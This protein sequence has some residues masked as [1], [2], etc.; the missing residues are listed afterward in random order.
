MLNIKIGC[1]VCSIWQ[2]SSDMIGSDTSFRKQEQESVTKWLIDEQQNAFCKEFCKTLCYTMN[3][4]FSF[5][6]ARKM[7]KEDLFQ[8]KIK[9]FQDTS[10]Q[11]PCV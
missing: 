9:Y 11:V 2:N 8:C 5:L 1:N 7:E 6:Y 3:V 10:V 4:R